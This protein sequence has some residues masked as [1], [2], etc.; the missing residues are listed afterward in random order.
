M[1]KYSLGEIEKLIESG[2]KF[3]FYFNQ[4]IVTKSNQ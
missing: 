3:A 1:I 2:E 4:V